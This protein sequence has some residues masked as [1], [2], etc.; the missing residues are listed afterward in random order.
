MVYFFIFVILITKILHATKFNT[1]SKLIAFTLFISFAIGSYSQTLKRTYYDEYK[2]TMLLE[3]YY[4]NSTGYGN[5]SYKK[6][7][8][9]GNLNLK[10]TYKDGSKEGVWTSYS[11]SSGKQEVSQTETFKNNQLNGLAVY[12]MEGSLVKEKGN[13]L[14]DKRDGE[15][16]ILQ[17]Y[18]SYGF[19]EEIKKGA[20]YIKGTF[21]Y[22]EGVIV[23][24]D[25]ERKVIFYPSGEVHSIENYLDGKRVGDQIWYN[26]DGTIKFQQ[27]FDTAE[28]LELK[29]QNEL[30]VIDSALIALEN[31]DFSQAEELFKTIKYNDASSAMNFLVQAKKFSEEK[32]YKATIENITQA[33]RRFE[34]ARIM[35]Y[36]KTNY[37]LY[38][39]DL[40]AKVDV[41]SENLDAEGLLVELKKQG[42][43]VGNTDLERYNLIVESTKKSLQE[44]ME[45]EKKVFEFYGKYLKDNVVAKETFLLDANGKPIMKNTYPKGEYLYL[46]S[47][48]VVDQ[49]HMEFLKETDYSRKIQ[50]GN[51]FIKAIESLNSIPESE[52][53]D[54]NKQLKKIDDSEQIKSIL[55]I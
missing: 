52:W 18:D 38:I 2:K 33:Y 40:D 8:K 54:L 4:V 31:E 51:K 14:N 23:Y 27:H 46:K 19:S 30:K 32:N 6:Y 21:H 42:D 47:R 13:Y 9:D 53:K 22:K 3:E 26:P 1:M 43:L 28:E 34:D 50:L 24:P 35:N 44:Q 36:Y 15:W 55:K 5:G 45:I 41:L 12:Y 16:E 11:R 29:K 49:Y 17:S 7:W 39:A 37:K 25:G 10:G 48:I 20:K